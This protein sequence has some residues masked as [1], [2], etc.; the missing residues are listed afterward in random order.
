MGVARVN[1]GTTFAPKHW[2]PVDL[3]EDI[4]RSRNTKPDEIFG[5]ESEVE[6]SDAETF[7]LHKQKPCYIVEPREDRVTELA[8]Q[9]VAEG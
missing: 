5:T 7:E 3:V 4:P 1:F 6:S 2:I 9:M 8:N